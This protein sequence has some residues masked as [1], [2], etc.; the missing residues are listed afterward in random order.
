MSTLRVTGTESCG[1][2]P[3]NRTVAEFVVALARG[4]RPALA[5]RVADT[6]TLDH[7]TDPGVP[8]TEGRESVVD[9][10]CARVPARLTALHVDGVATHGKDA[11]AWG[12]WTAD[13]VRAFWFLAGTFRT[14]KAEEF[15]RLRLSTG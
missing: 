11:A 1:N 5:A 7:A 2:S 4:D 9:A 12:S 8:G 6:C 10:L 15:A 13:G 14:V 3:K